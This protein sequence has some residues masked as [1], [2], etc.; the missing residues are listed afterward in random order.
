MLMDPRP[1]NNLCLLCLSEIKIYIAIEQW[2]GIEWK[3]H[4]VLNYLATGL[5]RALS[6]RNVTM[7][8]N[9]EPVQIRDL[10]KGQKKLIPNFTRI[11]NFILTYVLR[12]C[13][14][15]KSPYERSHTFTNVVKVA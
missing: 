2:K 4:E 9:I 10:K 3:I 13:R 12:M 11:C 15:I 8:T 6:L 5:L 7:A 1:I 14:S